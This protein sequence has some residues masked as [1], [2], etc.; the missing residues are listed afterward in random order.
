MAAILFAS[1]AAHALVT[2]ILTRKVNDLALE[3]LRPSQIEALPSCKTNIP[4]KPFPFST[5]YTCISSN[6]T[7]RN[8]IGRL[9]D[10]LAAQ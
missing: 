5:L 8:N 10:K 9:M 3:S 2:L 4:S 1:I 7:E 6:L